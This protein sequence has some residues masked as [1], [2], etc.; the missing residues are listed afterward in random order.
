MNMPRDHEDALTSQHAVDVLIGIMDERIEK[1]KASVERQLEGDLA[2]L[3]DALVA[4]LLAVDGKELGGKKEAE[5][6]KKVTLAAVKA[7]V[8]DAQGT[9]LAEAPIIAALHSI[10]ASEA[11]DDE[12]EG[13][14]G[15]GEEGGDDDD[16][17]EGEGEVLVSHRGGFPPAASFVVDSGPTPR[18]ARGAKGKKSG[19]PPLS[20][21]KP[22]PPPSDSSVD[23]ELQIEP[24]CPAASSTSGGSGSAPGA[25]D[26][27]A[28]AVEVATTTA[29]TTTATTAATTALPAAVSMTIVDAYPWRRELWD[30]FNQVAGRN[31]L[32]RDLPK[33]VV[34]LLPPPRVPPW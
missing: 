9:E 4:R 31:K 13:A 10:M 17:A 30:Y 8:A 5:A 16:A 22:R 33:Y 14:A 6:K 29:A 26:D 32:K 1:K 18:G 27:S 15:E 25:D 23:S 11:V 19:P 34:R 7:V 28:A 2:P 21:A 24:A 12:E 3:E 20:S